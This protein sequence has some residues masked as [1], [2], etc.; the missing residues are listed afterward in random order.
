MFLK[1][2]STPNDKKVVHVAAE[3]MTVLLHYTLQAQK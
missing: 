2:N 1:E 3:Y